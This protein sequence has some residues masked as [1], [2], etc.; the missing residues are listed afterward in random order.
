M[1]AIPGD[2]GATDH[3]PAGGA[4]R[5]VLLLTGAAFLLGACTLG[6][7]YKRPDVAVPAKWQGYAGN[8]KKT[9]LAGWWRRLNDP[10]LDRIIAMAMADNLDVATAKT[11]VTAGADPAWLRDGP[12]GVSW[13]APEA[14][15]GLTGWSRL[16]RAGVL[17]LR[18]VAELLG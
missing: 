4:S 7:N 10:V 14:L 6:P 2:H 3:R 8:G 5:P 12:F 15:F 18:L 13:L 16:G 1:T 11:A 17:V 9:E